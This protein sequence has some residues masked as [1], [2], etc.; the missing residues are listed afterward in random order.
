MT[1]KHKMLKVIEGNGVTHEMVSIFCR[2]LRLFYT[3]VMNG[4]D[5]RIREFNFF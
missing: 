2:H 1:R 4:G 3:K 5:I